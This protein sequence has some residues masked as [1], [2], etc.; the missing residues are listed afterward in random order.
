MDRLGVNSG[1][2]EIDCNN[3]MK[4]SFIGLEVQWNIV[5]MGIDGQFFNV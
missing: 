2:K 1:I 5:L 3:K 4:Y